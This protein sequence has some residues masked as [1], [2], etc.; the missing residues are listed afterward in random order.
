VR[1]WA[2]QPSGRRRR[3]LYRGICGKKKWKTFASREKVGK[4]S[5][6]GKNGR[7]SPGYASSMTGKG[8]AEN[9]KES[10]KSWYCTKVTFHGQT[11]G[12]VNVKR[13]K[14]SAWESQ[15]RIPAF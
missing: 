1:R 14:V 3:S 13:E 9:Q 15:P 4:G 10:G 6:V 11:G 5:C 7:H 12:K 8:E 2:I